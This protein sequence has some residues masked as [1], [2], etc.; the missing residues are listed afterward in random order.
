MICPNCE[1]EF[2]EGITECPDCGIKLVTKEEFEGKLVHHSDWVVVYT[3]NE[4]YKAEMY[5]A[6]LEGADIEATILGQKDRSYPAVGDLAVVKIMVKKVDAANA[7]EIIEDINAN[8][9]DSEEEE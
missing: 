5:K 1:Y 6:N 9:E 4:V 2:I 7:L 3:T 8:R